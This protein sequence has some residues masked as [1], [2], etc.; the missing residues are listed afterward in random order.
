ML[1]IITI[2]NKN[3]IWSTTVDT[4]DMISA[5]MFLDICRIRQRD[6]VHIHFKKPCWYQHKYSCIWWCGPIVV[7]AENHRGMLKH[8]HWW[9]GDCGYEC[10][11][12]DFSRVEPVTLFPWEI[13]NIF[14]CMVYIFFEIEWVNRTGSVQTSL[15]FNWPSI[16]I[17]P[18]QKTNDCT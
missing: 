1:L 12:Q 15:I 9:S 7:F 13:S 17:I 5:I 2:L 11:R 18:Y 16:N 14:H 6:G 4:E 8:N 10:S 3:G